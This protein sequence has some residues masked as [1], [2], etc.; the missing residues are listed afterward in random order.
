MHWRLINQIR[1]EG[2]DSGCLLD[3]VL[4]WFWEITDREFV[5]SILVFTTVRMRRVYSYYTT[6]LLAFFCCRHWHLHLCREGYRET[7]SGQMIKLQVII[8][9]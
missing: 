3:W 6:I 7:W 9:V 8:L 1:G 5:D 2:C 4:I